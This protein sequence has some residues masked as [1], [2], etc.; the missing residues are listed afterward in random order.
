MK[1]LIE[2]ETKKINGGKDV[3]RYKIFYD[4]D[5]GNRVSRYF[6]LFSET[7]TIKQQE[8][9]AKVFTPVMKDINAKTFYEIMKEVEKVPG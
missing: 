9:I 2:N 7:T 3:N 5:D 6:L 4:G 1:K 8:D